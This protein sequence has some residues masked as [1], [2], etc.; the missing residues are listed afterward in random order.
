MIDQINLAGINILNPG[1][2]GIKCPKNSIFLA[3]LHFTPKRLWGSSKKVF[4]YFLGLYS[5]TT[6]RIFPIFFMNVE[7]SR[8][9]CLSKVV[10]LKKFLMTNCRGH[11]HPFY[12][13]NNKWHDQC[14]SSYRWISLFL[15]KIFIRH[16][17]IPKMDVSVTTPNNL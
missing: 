15:L 13:K 4:F 16:T 11:F 8:A 14:H 6:R 7:D 1:L 3:S 5:K 9:H 12:I 2:H 10:F 17:K